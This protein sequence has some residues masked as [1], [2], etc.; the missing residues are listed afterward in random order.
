MGGGGGEGST[1]KEQLGLNGA[2]KSAS[3]R[4]SL[5]QTWELREIPSLAESE[6]GKWP[7]DGTQLAGEG[8]AA[9]HPQPP[10]RL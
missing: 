2:I 9:T 6:V 1:V 3:W 10:A 4:E 5:S 8:G 7:D